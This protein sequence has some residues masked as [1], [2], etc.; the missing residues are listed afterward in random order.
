MA[1]VTE[2][3]TEPRVARVPTQPD[4]YDTDALYEVVDGLIVEKP[5]M[6]A[7]EAQVA[8]LLGKLLDRF[9]EASALGTV[10]T[11]ALFRLDATRK[12]DRRPDV[13]FVSQQRWPIERRAPRTAAWDVVPD[14]AVEVLSPGNRSVEDLTKVDE[15]FAAGVRL[16]WVIYPGPDRVYVYQSPTSVRILTRTDRLDGGEVLPGFSV[17]LGEL[18]GPEGVR[19]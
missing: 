7:F 16:V 12:L 14:L 4:S 11:E 5:S 8:W 1:T 15:Y 17:A 10:I 6:G 9:V 19:A 3:S 18:F 13:A 2:T